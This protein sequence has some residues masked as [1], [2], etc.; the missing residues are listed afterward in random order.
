MKLLKIHGLFVGLMVVSITH[1]F[2]YCPENCDNVHCFPKFDP[3]D[4]PDD[5]YF[6]PNVLMGCC[7][8]CVRY[9]FEGSWYE[10]TTLK[11][12][13]KYHSGTWIW[14]TRVMINSSRRKNWPALP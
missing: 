14:R 1:Q 2:D 7:P 5:S 6:M 12:F 3:G 13:L 8:A 10:S 9:D 11:V 4:C